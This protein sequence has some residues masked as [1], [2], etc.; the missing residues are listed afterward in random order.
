MFFAFLE[1]GIIFLGE[2]QGRG[3]H[4]RSTGAMQH[5]KFYMKFYIF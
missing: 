2:A 3:V 5:G 1:L 4:F